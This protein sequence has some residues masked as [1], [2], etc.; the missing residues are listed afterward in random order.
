MTEE[1]LREIDA[2]VARQ[3]ANIANTPYA[4]DDE[5]F[6]NLSA[7]LADHVPALLAEVRLLREVEQAIE[8]RIAIGL[9]DLAVPA[10]QRPPADL[11]P[12]DKLSEY[13]VPWACHQIQGLREFAERTVEREAQAHWDNEHRHFRRTCAWADA[14]RIAQDIER[15]ATRRRLGLLPPA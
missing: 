9:D 1:A 7:T 3:E 14:P 13:L 4:P 8:Q 11:H 12:A 15:D 10:D 6:W 2:L 5:E